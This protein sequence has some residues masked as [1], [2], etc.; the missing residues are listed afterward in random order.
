MLI[1]G[2]GIPVQAQTNLGLDNSF[3][4]TNL[5]F[6]YQLHPQKF[7]ENTIGT[8]SI[9]ALDNGKITPI[10]IDGLKV[11]SSDNTIVE[12]RDVKNADNYSTGIEILAKEPGLVNISLAAPDFKSQEIPIEIYNNNNHPTQILLKTTPND[13]P[14][15]GPKFGYIG[16]ELATTGNLPVIASEDITVKISTPNTDVIKLKESEITIQKG[17]YYALTE[18]DV[19]ES[20][21]AIVFAET[22]GMKKV[23]EFIHVREAATP[24]QLQLYVFPENFNSF[25][26]QTG[27]AIVQLQDAEGIPVKADKNIN[28]KIGVENPDSGINTSHDFEEFQFQT[29]ELE[30][31]EGS[32]ST[33]STFSVRPNISDFTQSFEQSYNFYLIADDYIANGDSIT[34]THDEIG[35]LEGEGPAITKTVPFLTTGEREIVGVT[36]FETQVT[37]SRQLGTS[38]IGV[39]DRETV[40]VTVPVVANK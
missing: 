36:Y 18:F 4:Q 20:G 19:K 16:I 14:V 40:T 28:L 3:T 24:L 31:K 8:I 33:H 38:T 11:S 22:E 2:G 27:Y 1:I 7:L 13:F 35:A 6:G 30:I 25:S 23:S 39:T 12:I 34:V 9:H 10:S 29:N 21:D 15:D 17:E 5:E 32:Y 26:T 37:V